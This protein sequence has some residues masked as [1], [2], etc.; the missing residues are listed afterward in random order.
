M[1]VS[2][3]TFY[4]RLANF[5]DRSVNA[6][7]LFTLPVN[8]IRTH[9]RSDSAHYQRAATSQIILFIQEP[10][11]H[12]SDPLHPSAD[13]EIHRLLDATFVKPFVDATSATGKLR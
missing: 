7:L 2:T 8:W 9:I 13:G 6:Q 1:L 3:I 10:I 12:A 5:F 4:Q 11:E